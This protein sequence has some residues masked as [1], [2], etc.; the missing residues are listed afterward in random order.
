MRQK[1][2]GKFKTGYLCLFA[3]EMTPDIH[4]SQH[5]FNDTMIISTT[6]NNDDIKYFL[7]ISTLSFHSALQEDITALFTWYRDSELD[8]NFKKFVYLTFK[9]KLDTTYRY[10][11]HLTQAYHTV[12]LIKTLD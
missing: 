6:V 10:T 4:V 5:N 7:H 8:C 3:C 2:C 9:C 12:I 11:L 1:N